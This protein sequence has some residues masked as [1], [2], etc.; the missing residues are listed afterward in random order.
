[1]ADQTIV[2]IGGGKFCDGLAD[3]LNGLTGKE[4]PRVLYIGTAS[5]EDPEQALRTYDRFGSFGDVTRLEFFPWPPEDLRS[6]VLD[7]DLIFVGGGNTANMLAVW[8]AHGMD[9]ILREAWERGIV[10]CGQSAGAM[11]WFEFG[12]T[13]SSGRP[14]PARGLGLLP[15]TLSVHHGRDPQRRAALLDEIAS[16]E[17]PGGYALD[18]GAGLLFEGTR[19]VEAFAGTRGARVV[20]VEREG[21]GVV[22]RELHPIPLR[23]EL[24]TVDPAI[25]E[26]RAL[27]RMKAAA[28]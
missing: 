28:R 25:A 13:A 14:V 9:A 24:P 11:C 23:Q 2:P 26:R 6:T 27:R 4:R 18:D 8:R 15:G 17:L 19:P 21:A 20:R 3:F 12:I 16:R 22:E 10:L 5:A 1:M 7:Q